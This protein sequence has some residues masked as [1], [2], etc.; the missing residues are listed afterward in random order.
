MISCAPHRVPEGRDV[1][2]QAAKKQSVI[3]CEVEGAIGIIRDT[4][5]RPFCAAAT[6]QGREQLLST[7]EAWSKSDT[8][9]A[10][11]FLGCAD[12]CGDQE[13][14]EV[15]EWARQAKLKFPLER[16]QTTE[17]EIVQAILNNR[18]I[19]IYA[20][21]GLII[22]PL[23]SIIM[24]CDYSLVADNTVFL[25]SFHKHNMAPMGGGVFLLTRLL[26]AR[27]A[28]R[29]L[30]STEDMPA[31]KAAEIGLVDE[32]APL[33]NLEERARAK[34]LEFARLPLS[35]VWGIKRL[36]RRA[37][38]DLDDFTQYERQ[39]VMDVFSR[40]HSARS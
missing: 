17:T 23:V 34:A 9:R 24:A 21:G 11:L 25:K 10:I 32:I 40:A 19:I 29:L 8:V 22:S 26:G 28:R 14:A 3:S 7:L 31:D 1:S 6:L 35:A 36:M 12:K 38:G 37:I 2:M 4:G 5:R 18:K 30:L 27:T 15:L 16:A 33:A 39:I 13:Y 20:D